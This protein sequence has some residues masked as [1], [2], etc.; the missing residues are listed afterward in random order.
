MMATNYFGVT[1][2]LSPHSTPPQYRVTLRRTLHLSTES[3]RA[4]VCVN[5]DVSW[6]IFHVLQE[7]HQLDRF[8]IETK[9]GKEW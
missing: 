4:G 3:G 5:R 7:Q 6:V 9:D 1:S 8:K 2:S